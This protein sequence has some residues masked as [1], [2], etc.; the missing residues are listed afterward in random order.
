MAAPCWEESGGRGA[1]AVPGPRTRRRRSAK[2]ASG[3]NPRRWPPTQPGPRGPRAASIPRGAWIAPSRTSWRR[4]TATAGESAGGAAS[5]G[6]RPRTAAAGRGERRS[7][8]PTPRRRRTSARNTGKLRASAKPSPA[9]QWRRAATAS[10]SETSDGNAAEARRRLSA[11]SGWRP[12]PRCWVGTHRKTTARRVEC[13]HRSPKG[14]RKSGALPP[15]S[16]AVPATIGDNLDAAGGRAAG[17]N[18]RCELGSCD[19]QGAGAQPRPPGPSG[20]C[21]PDDR[22]HRAAQQRVVEVDG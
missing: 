1:P 13:F 9:P 3:A 11:R 8:R 15:T 21:P 18:D 19:H 4:T 16:S 5:W 14:P 22:P 7:P 10:V 17:E 6:S 2:H 20:A 12:L